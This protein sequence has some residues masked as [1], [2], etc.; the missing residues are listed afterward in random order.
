VA[1]DWRK[2]NNEELRNLYSSPNIIRMI[3][4]RR[5]SWTEH[6]AGMGAKRIAYR[7]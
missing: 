5:M 6:V 2:L 7:I 3:T 1:G 4:S